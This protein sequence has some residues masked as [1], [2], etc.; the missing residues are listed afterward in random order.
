M[1]ASGAVAGL[2]F[3]LGFDALQGRSPG[4]SAWLLAGLLGAVAFAIPLLVNTILLTAQLKLID[5][6]LAVLQGGL[7]GFVAGIGAWWV[8]KTSRP[9]WLCLSTVS[10]VAGLALLVGQIIAGALRASGVI[11]KQMPGI[12]PSIDLAPQLV[13]IFLAGAIAPLTLLLVGRRRKSEDSVVSLL[14]SRDS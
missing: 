6:L 8:S 13:A 7:W 11:I 1:A 5:T 9:P 12:I 14:Q 10:L 3:F 2:I 4:W